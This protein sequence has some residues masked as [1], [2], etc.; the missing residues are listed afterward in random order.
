MTE[1]EDAHESE[2]RN[3]S[4]EL[5]NVSS[6]LRNVSSE[7]RNVSSVPGRRVPQQL[8]VGELAE[9]GEATAVRFV[10][11]AEHLCRAPQN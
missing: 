7:L 8:L 5:R 11:D 3:V 6:E 9:G 4:S 10:L 1:D 2:L